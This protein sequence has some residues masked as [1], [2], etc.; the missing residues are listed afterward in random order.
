M[1]ISSTNFLLIIIVLAILSSTTFA[2]KTFLLKEY[3]KNLYQPRVQA[4]DGT[5]CFFDNS[6]DH[7]CIDH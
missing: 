2:R 7:W 5:T 6:I 4:Y 1:K 3:H